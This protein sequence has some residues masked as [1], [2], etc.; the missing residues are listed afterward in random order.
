MKIF[1]SAVTVLAVALA[2]CVH[3]HKIPETD[4]N[5]AAIDYL[6]NANQQTQ[7]TEAR[8]VA[9]L[10]SAKTALVGMK[11]S[12]TR[13]DN[14]LVYNEAASHLTLLLRS[15]EH[16]K[17][18]NRPVTLS[19]GG[20]TYRVRYAPGTR[21]SQ[22]DPKQFT[23][24]VPAADVK[25][26]DIKR[27]NEIDGVGGAL[28]GIHQASPRQEF[29][30]L[31]GVTAAV[32][33][34]LDFQGS[35]VTL[36]LVNP[37]KTAQTMLAGT[38]QPLEANFSAP[39]EH[40]PHVSELW[41]G[42][43]GAIK[44]ERYM[45][46]TGLYMLQPYDP[47]KIPLIFVHGLISTARKWRT[48]INEIER[49]PILR[50]RYQCWVFSYPTGNPP[51]YSAMRLREEL[52]KVKKRYP[53][54]KDFVLVG[55]SMGGLLSQMQVR[56][57]NRSDWDIIG[58]EKAEMFFSRVKPGSV[59]H[60]SLIFEANPHVD[61]VV[62]IC[63]PHRGSNMAAGGV[64]SL[65]KKMIA[66]PGDIASQL[67]TSL[68]D[69]IAILTGDS[70]RLPNSVSG[71]SPTNPTLKVIDQKPIIAPYHSIIG[72]RGEGNTPKSSD[73][74]VEYWSSSLK[75]AESELIVPG[76][77]GACQ[78]PETIAELRRILHLQ[79]RH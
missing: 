36:R 38:R 21:D 50:S 73:G 63:T 19:H 69:S 75:G 20:K 5:H 40:Y 25:R 37:T 2:S 8:A 9:Y 30:P 23:S 1:S 74:V 48:V 34:I 51:S 66:L 24:F 43:M 65:A 39:L 70:K 60:K 72:D 62:F 57:V 77:H 41:S 49:D 11:S 13:E 42:L 68:G 79:L 35:D 76:P 47:D 56:S 29:A 45:D 61:R 33:A 71:L 32:S 44:V 55:H 64:G 3:S 78:L 10:D 58:K 16:G 31:V 15:A 27:A 28:V 12:V 26:P 14:R 46:I 67:T 18:W 6:E 54:A 59:I 4:R 52:V 7:S 53:N 17:Y 22:W